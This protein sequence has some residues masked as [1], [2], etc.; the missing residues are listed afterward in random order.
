MAMEKLYELCESG[1]YDVVVVD[2]PPTRNALD[3]LDAPRRLTSFLENR[4]FRA[5]LAPTRLYLRAVSV[6][7]RALLSTIGSVAGAEL[8]SDAVTF[9]QAFAGMEEGFTQRA[10]A[11]HERLRA[12]GT[13]FVLITSPRR[14]AIGEAR[15]FA[16]RLTEAGMTT[17]GVIVNRVQP[18]F[19]PGDIPTEL[20]SADGALGALTANLVALEQVA[21]SEQTALGE[22]R[23]AAAP[24][25]LA[26]I[27]L[28]SDEIHDVAGLRRLA[29]HLE[30]GDEQAP[31]AG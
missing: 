8:V 9:F 2:T 23:E 10:N 22:L 31:A 6:A 20:R 11:V 28:R 15:Y 5:L 21:A 19:W 29:R 3:L 24:A 13:A 14:D 1:R 17:A 26:S 30:E 18:R 25:P 16:D 27:P 12:P 7:T 4:L